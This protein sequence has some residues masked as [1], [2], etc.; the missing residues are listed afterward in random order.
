MPDPTE[1][2]T[3]WPGWLDGLTPAERV[4][5]IAG[6]LDRCSSEGRC[7]D[8]GEHA[9][10]RFA[11]LS[12]PEAE[13]FLLRLLGEARQA[14][15]ESAFTE[16]MDAHRAR[17]DQVAG[18]AEPA[19]VPSGKPQHDERCCMTGAPAGAGPHPDCPGHHGWTADGH[20]GLTL[21]YAG[22][23]PSAEGRLEAVRADVATLLDGIG[24]DLFLAGSPYALAEDRLRAFAKGGESAAV[25]S[26]EQ[27][28]PVAP[29]PV[30]A[31]LETGAALVRNLSMRPGTGSS[32]DAMAEAWQESYRALAA[33]YAAGKAEPA[34]EPEPDPEPP[35]PPGFFGRVELPGWRN[36][37]GWFT[38]G[39]GDIR[40]VSDWD[41]NVIAEFVQGPNCLVIHLPTPQK[42]PDPPKAITAAP[43]PFGSGYPD[44]ED[45]PWGGYGDDD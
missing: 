42:R 6:A 8:D 21:D 1:T 31:L 12:R 36:Y 22:R 30:M 40:L 13:R 11:H 34:A 33:E 10:D 17:I 41:G 9:P 19:A 4:T 24:E 26:A 37:T 39:G 44:D 28:Q 45:S 5:A 2:P 15:Y 38:S 43:Q 23:R 14:G 3:P 29:E 16:A 27:P 32:W 7:A 20:G 35:L 25:P 18:P